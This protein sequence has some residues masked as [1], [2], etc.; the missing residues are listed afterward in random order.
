MHLF[1]VR[2]SNVAQEN[3]T[4]NPVVYEF[5]SLWFV[6]ICFAVRFLVLLLVFVMTDILKDVKL[7]SVAD[8]SHCFRETC[9]LHLKS[10]SE[11]SYFLL[12]LILVC[13]C[14]HL[15]AIGCY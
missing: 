3:Q 4:V 10:T 1:N 15:M 2:A 8:R 14:L 13:G 9:C 11:L 12:M 6:K 7:Y 5:H